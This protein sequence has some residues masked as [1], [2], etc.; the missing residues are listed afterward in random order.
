MYFIKNGWYQEV[1]LTLKL[2]DCWTI[3]IHFIL[4]KRL[5][6]EH[7]IHIFF[8]TIWKQFYQHGNFIHEAE[9]HVLEFYISSVILTFKNIYI[10]WDLLC[11]VFG[12]G[13]LDPFRICFRHLDFVLFSFFQSSWCVPNNHKLHLITIRKK[14]W[15]YSKKIKV[16][17]KLRELNRASKCC[18]SYFHSLTNIT[19]GFCTHV[20]VRNEGLPNKEHVHHSVSYPECFLLSSL[21]SCMA[22]GPGVK[23]PP[24]TL[25]I[26]GVST[27]LTLSSGGQEFWPGLG[28]PTKCEKEQTGW[29]KGRQRLQKGEVERKCEA[30]F[31]LLCHSLI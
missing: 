14:I 29:N 2:F 19:R 10:F 30:H 3:G 6:S 27:A 1:F 5:T 8:Y 24:P 15:I 22:L 4:G 26:S 28:S 11:S 21:K 16:H 12:W 23:P 13:R 17:F 9:L 18:F 25:A 20:L 7:K 31:S